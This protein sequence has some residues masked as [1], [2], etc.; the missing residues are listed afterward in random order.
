MTNSSRDTQPRQSAWAAVG[1]K[2]GKVLWGLGGHY[3]IHA[4]RAMAELD[5]P[6]YGEVR[7]VSIRVLPKIREMR[8]ILK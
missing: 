1:K 3:S 5:C 8:G 4:D 7:A 6:S 2:S